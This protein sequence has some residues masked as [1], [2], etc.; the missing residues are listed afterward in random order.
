MSQNKN[1]SFFYRNPR[2]TGFLVFLVIFIIAQSLTLQR[3]MLNLSETE[4]ENT[5]ELNS[6]IDQLQYN[7]NYAL[8]T[9]NT[10]AFIVEN[11]GVPRDY[12]SIAKKLLETNTLIDG[13]QLLQ[14]GTI[15]HTYP[16]EGN[17]EVIG[18][19]VAEDPSRRKE[20]FMAAEKG[21]MYFA[22][23][24]ELRQGGMGI[25]GRVPLN[26]END[27][28]AFA[29]VVIR[30]KKLLERSGISNDKERFLYQISKI[31]PQTGVMEYFIDTEA[32]FSESQVAT[33][34]IPLGQ[35]I[36]YVK[37]QNPNYFR[38]ILQLALLGLVL[39][40]MAGFLTWV[41]VRRPE[42]LEKL[43][44]RQSRTILE[45]QRLLQALVQNS[46]DAVA[47]IS[48]DGSN[49]YVSPS[50]TKV[51]GYTVNE[52]MKINL[53]DIL[54]DDDKPFVAEEMQYVLQNPGKTI[55]GHVS[56]IRHK[57]GSWRWI[58][59]SITNLL[60]D[61]AVNGIVDNFRDITDRKEA[62]DQLIKEK[63][64]SE[65]I[66]D[67]LPGIFYLS[68]KEGRVLVWNQNFEKVSGYTGEEIAKM[69]PIDF[70]AKEDQQYISDRI[71]MVFEDGESH[72]ET[73]FYTKNK[74]KIYYYFTG[75][76]ILYENEICL[77]GTG[78]DL[79]KRK[80]A[81]EELEKSEEQ[82][83]SIF[84]NSISA[85]IMMDGNGMITNWNTTAE[86]MFGWKSEE[87]LNKPMHHFIMPEKHV[88]AHLEG[89]ENYNK[90]GNGPIINTNT[91]L[92]AITKSK[93]EIDISLGVTTVKIRGKEYFIGF[94]NDITQQKEAER[95]KE[96]EKRNREALI[97][98]TEDQIWS[99]SQEITLISANDAFKKS[100]AIYTGIQIK[101]G[102]YTLA[103]DLFETEYLNLWKGYY[104]RGL[105]GERFTVE[106]TVP[107]KAKQEK[108]TVETSFSPILVNNDVVGVACYAR[109][110]TQRIKTEEE[111][112]DYNEKLKTAQEI[113]QLGYWEHVKGEE[114]LF[115]SD[116][117]YRIWEL[118]K[119]TYTPTTTS[120]FEAVVPA[121]REKFY[122]YSNRPV[123]LVDEQDI[124][125][126]IITATGKLKWIHQY[127]QKVEDHQTNRTLFKGTIRD[128]THQKTQEE[129]ILEFNEK[130]Q[131]AQ[132]IAKL[133]YWEFD[134]KNEKLTWSDQVYEIWEKSEKTFKVSP[135]AFYNTIHPDDF[136][137]YYTEQKKALKGEKALEKEHRIV[138][139][140]GKI[141]WVLERGE[142]VFNDKGDPLIFEGT[143]QDITG[144]KLIELELREQNHF[145]KTAIDNLPVGIA[146]R[147]IHTGKFTLM[148]KNFTEIYGWSQRELR[149][150]NTFF[151]KVYPDPEYR[152]KIKNQIFSDLDSKDTERM[153][154]EGLQVTTKKGANRI[155]N[156][157]NIPLYDQNLMIS[158]VLD[159]TEKYLAEQRLAISNERY[160]YVTKATFDAVWDW[161]FP[162]NNMFWGEGFKTIFGHDVENTSPE[163][164]YSNIHPDDYERI[165]KSIE[166]AI[167]GNGRNWE[168]EYRFKHAN[169]T[170]RFVK[171]RGIILRN[172]ERKALRMIGAL[173]DIT[174]Q[175]EYEMK[176]L[177]VNQKLRNLSAHL[178]EAR[179][180][181]RISIAREIHDE[182]GQQLTGIKLDV[183]WLKSKVDLNFPEDGER[184]VRLIENINKTINDVRK[185]ASHLRP[186]VLDDLGLEAA[187]EWQTQQFQT[188]TGINCTLH[189]E[190]VSG[191]YGKEINTA[192]YRI[193]Q[194]ALT[195]VMRHA[196]AT[197]V[198]TI[199]KETDNTLTLEVTDNGIGIDDADKN[200][201]F[202]LGIT[203]MRERALMIN[204][205]FFVKKQK[206]GG[207]K[208]KV[209]V[210]LNS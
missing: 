162:A 53:F 85:V 60:D 94:I 63:N 173:Q 143:V 168:N 167:K 77:L 1:R 49:K 101:E 18:Y 199:F 27:S 17:E 8:S 187:I 51:L 172:V 154:W 138:L 58:E 7:L 179:E 123:D 166:N 182:L 78:I 102:D 163:F 93:K 103:D 122:L 44:Y 42:E 127:G 11:Y 50:V 165:K 5:E 120:F 10:L 16:L 28:L 183:S 201:T 191:N 12:D 161:D 210:N 188:Q 107:P 185:I 181:E 15:T 177:D 39:S 88:Q 193:Y 190:N 98:A 110:I 4:K 70:F 68:N 115:W 69:T 86:Q 180:E 160:E 113:A 145:I 3:Y 121:D 80:Q 104:E 61:P 184:T 30:M 67:S 155:I 71:N 91:E 203:G 196:Q 176:L 200:N 150:V 135:E 54:H 174:S 72:A 132:K 198:E 35:W 105:K 14:D 152:N 43:V 96:Y 22:G 209:S 118:D 13:V 25:V 65:A 21:Q 111:I 124:E 45:N 20:V 202:S 144:Q 189:F 139:D 97:N 74:E 140:S 83:L 84:N 38:G 26:L 195:N 146:V 175:K 55:L 134:F 117:I 87:V 52:I 164:W 158:T 36:V 40:V 204:A 126:R 153:Q 178:Q 129:A 76:T 106:T 142:L 206:E 34:E 46:L 156:A 170:Y 125:Y 159:V 48:P 205:E 23:P 59:S 128:I 131:T 108:K 81:E 6:V 64:L 192:I 112:K 130:L 47:I 57:D 79:S 186:G 75:R 207:T 148:N 208:V 2:I 56:R 133:G 149:D 114:I 109:D 9:T 151:E 31:N 197:A 137:E 147:N 89:M 19:K 37:E 82:L 116:Q 32:D 95:Q 141:K 41:L 119:E 29:A 136:E 194:E 66:I 157:R 24:F 169:G 90:T 62:Q 33:I 73:Y 100:F 92:T 99:V 171:D